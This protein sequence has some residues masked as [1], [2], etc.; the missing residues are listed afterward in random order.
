L[1]KSGAVGEGAARAAE[2][3]LLA[4]AR[5]GDQDA[6]RALW[7][8]AERAAY[9]VCLHVTGNHH[10][11]LDALQDTQLAAWRGLGRFAH[12][13]SF[14]SWVYAIGRNAAL[15]VVRRSAGAPVELPE[16][17]A[18]GRTPFDDVVADRLAVRAA[19][20]A[21][22]QPRRDALLLW[23]G[24][25]SYAQIAAE[26]DVPIDTVKVWIFRARRAVRGAVAPA[27]G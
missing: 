5:A 20:A 16:D 27:A 9:A 17:R 11:A 4:A 12:R 15:A 14:S 10:D 24:G 19:L 3:E 18:D 25:L 2:A 23:V 1:N 26:L 6:F 7:A 22:P 8:T 13:A 21:L